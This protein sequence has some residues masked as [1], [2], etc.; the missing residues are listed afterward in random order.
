MKQLHLNCRGPHWLVSWVQVSQDKNVISELQ[1]TSMA[2]F[3]GSGQA[4]QKYDIWTA[5]DL[6]GSFL[7]CSG[8]LWCKCYTWFAKDLHGWF[9][10]F[11]LV[12]ILK[13]HLNCQRPAWLS[14]RFILI[15]R[16]HQTCW[17]TG[18]KLWECLHISNCQPP[19]LTMNP[20]SNHSPY[21][22]GYQPLLHH[23]SSLSTKP[24]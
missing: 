23:S 5:K 1:R 22:S 8:K 17:I 16:Q 24:S 20:F 12:L 7:G 21:I 18:Y 11:R 3:M 15:I 9:H 10:G 6:N 14:S 13:W 2:A 4:R 19:L